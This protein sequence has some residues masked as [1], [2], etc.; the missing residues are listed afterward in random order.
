LE[1]LSSISRSNTQTLLAPQDTQAEPHSQH[2]ERVGV[3]GLS[4]FKQ[5]NHCRHCDCDREQSVAGGRQQS[6]PTYQN[7]LLNLDSHPRVDPALVS[8]DHFYAQ[9]MQ[10]EASQPR[11]S[12]PHLLQVSMSFPT[13]WT[14]SE[15]KKMGCHVQA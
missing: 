2:S 7:D 3:R 8:M 6:T 15:L 12:C 4:I 10:D 14:L 1:A 13:E 11:P 5:R 9:T